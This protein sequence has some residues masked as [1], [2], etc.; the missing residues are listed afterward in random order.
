MQQYKTSKMT[1]IYHIKIQLV[2]WFMLIKQIMM[3]IM[4]GQKASNEWSILHIYMW[5]L[6][7]D[8]ISLDL[9]HIIWIKLIINDI[10]YLSKDND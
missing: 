3:S 9:E 4:A 5:L 8:N 6:I 10:S 7:N 2:T 1:L